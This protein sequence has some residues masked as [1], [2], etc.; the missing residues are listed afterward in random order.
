[1][2]SAIKTLMVV[3]AMTLLLAGCDMDKRPVKTP[4]PV[5]TPDNPN[6]PDSRTNI[7]K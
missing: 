1:M 6:N 5:E 4:P 2:K 7:E 3:S